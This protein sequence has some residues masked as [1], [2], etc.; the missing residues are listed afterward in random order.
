MA[1]KEKF[2][3]PEKKKYSVKKMLTQE[4]LLEAM[5]G[6]RNI[7]T[8][9]WDTMPDKQYER[10]EPIFDTAIASMMAHLCGVMPGQDGKCYEKCF[11]AA[12]GDCDGCER[13]GR[14]Q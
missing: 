3:K 9:L 1:S 13:Q 14:V 5:E 10:L 2:E 12:E 11:G 6:I 7:Q 8:N 4:R